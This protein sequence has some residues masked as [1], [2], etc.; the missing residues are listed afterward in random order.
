[1][2]ALSSIKDEAT[3]QAVAA[4]AGVRVDA[5]PA[6]DGGRVF[7]V[8]RWS[9]CRQCDTLDEVRELLLRMGIEA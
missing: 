6:D 3:V 5:I 8:S 9:L 7:I 1:M 2:S 4:R